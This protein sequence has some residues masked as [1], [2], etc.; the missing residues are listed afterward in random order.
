MLIIKY[1]KIAKVSLFQFNNNNLTFLVRFRIDD[2]E[3]KY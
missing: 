2:V 3:L 1:N